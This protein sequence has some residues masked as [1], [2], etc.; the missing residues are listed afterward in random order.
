M[1]SDAYAMIELVEHHQALEL[2]G[3]ATDI[4]IAGRDT[5]VGV[6]EQATVLE[7]GSPSLQGPP[8]ATGQPGAGTQS[9][10]IYAATLPL[11]GQR[12]VLFSPAL[13]GFVY[14]DRTI[15]Q[16]ASAQVA[17]T[18]GAINFGDS[19]PAILTGVIDEP[20]WAWPAPCILWLD[21]DRYLTA[22]PPTSGA[23]RE[24][25]RAISATRVFVDPQ[26]A[27]ILT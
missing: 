2:E 10:I 26:P 27:T 14:A 17:L 1:T 9:E 20:S 12:V 24:V 3:V 23:S 25:G 21:T 13:G 5:T 6:I 15:P 4:E 11:S 16:H 22:T 18:R 7:I 19:G 8:G